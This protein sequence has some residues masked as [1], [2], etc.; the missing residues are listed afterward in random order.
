MSSFDTPQD[1]TFWSPLSNNGTGGKTWSTPTT[2]KAMI[3]E[4]SEVIFSEEGKEIVASK[5][6]YTRTEMQKGYY[7]AVG[8]VTDLTPTSSAQQVI[9]ASINPLEANEFKAWLQ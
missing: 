6:V 1:V 2:I 8:K 7:V 5:S 4:A 9:K 3:A